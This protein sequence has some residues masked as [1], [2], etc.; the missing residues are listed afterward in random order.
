MSNAD[1]INNTIH[2]DRILTAF[3]PTSSEVT[4]HNESHNSKPENYKDPRKSLRELN[5]ENMKLTEELIDQ[6]LCLTS[7]IEKNS[8]NKSRL[9]VLLN[10][11][12]MQNKK[13]MEENSKMSQFIEINKSLHFCNSDSKSIQ[14]LHSSTPRTLSPSI[15]PFLNDNSNDYMAQNYNQSLDNSD[16]SYSRPSYNQS[17]TSLTNQNNFCSSH[18]LRKAGTTFGYTT[19]TGK[20]MNSV[21]NGQDIILLQNHITLLEKENFLLQKE[22]NVTKQHESH[23]ILK[24]KEKEMEIKDLYQSKEILIR[25]NDELKNFLKI[26]T[27]EANVTILKLA[28]MNQDLN[29]KTKNYQK[30]IDKLTN[31]IYELLTNKNN[32]KRDLSSTLLSVVEETGL[33][34]AIDHT[35]KSQNLTPNQSFNIGNEISTHDQSLFKENEILIQENEKLKKMKFALANNENQLI[36]TFKNPNSGKIEEEII[37]NKKQ[38][39]LKPVNSNTLKA[40]ISY[41][42][43]ASTLSIAESNLKNLFGNITKLNCVNDQK[44][45]LLTNAL[46]KPITIKKMLDSNR[47]SSVTPLRNN[48]IKPNM[49]RNLFY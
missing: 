18:C 38:S 5:L 13:L 17:S 11:Q 14:I 45:N 15:K 21:N 3:F 37:N 47:T 35:W 34:S 43:S 6:D 4:I 9:F 16:C 44:D 30:V 28:Q 33:S 41:K 46:T 31:E 29:N 49:E 23:K 40:F 36:N 22:I 8:N 25:E 2:D 27:E 1:R 20:S 26:R 42:K 10:E 19:S 7:N 24:I 32:C 39:P 48:K 12:K